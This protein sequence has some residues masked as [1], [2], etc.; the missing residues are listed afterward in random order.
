M[1]APLLRTKRNVHKNDFGHVLIL[2]GSKQMLGAAALC[3]L[4]AMRAGAGLATIGIPKSL[5]LTLQKKISPV[6]MTWSLPE[7][8]EQ[9]LSFKAYPAIKKRLNSFDCVAIGPG[10]ST[11]T[12]TQKLIRKII[13]TADKPLVIDADAL[14]ALAKDLKVLLK[15]PSE[16]VLTPHPGEMARL[17]GLSKKMIENSGLKIAQQFSAQYHCILLLK[18]SRTIVAAPNGKTYINKTGNPGMATAGSG[19]VLTGMIAAFLAQGIPAFDAAKLG[20]YLHGKAGD[21]AARK[22]TRLALIATDIIDEIPKVIKF[23]S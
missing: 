3:A 10:L 17:T 22:K 13:T 11:N 4:S 14:N 20:A 7:T 15:N 21:I 9:T 23:S 5:N 2:A 6:I 19:D 1:P 12:Q 16:K 8:K 18:G